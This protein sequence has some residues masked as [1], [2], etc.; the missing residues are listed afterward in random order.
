MATS[1]Q[2]VLLRLKSSFKWC[3]GA[4]NEDLELYKAAWQCLWQSMPHKNWNASTFLLKHFYCNSLILG[5]SHSVGT[6]QHLGVF[7]LPRVCLQSIVQDITECWCLGHNG[8]G[9]VTAITYYYAFHKI[10]WVHSCEHFELANTL[11][12]YMSVIILTPV[13]ISDV[14]LHFNLATCTCPLYDFPLT[15]MNCATGNTSVLHIAFAVLGWGN[16][17][18][19]REAEHCNQVYFSQEYRI[20]LCKSRVDANDLIML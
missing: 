8:R 1:T 13:D 18:G 11:I 10:M 20:S 16:T 12:A 15:C 5:S 6:L 19:D 4:L 9:I 17:Q 7:L 14:L 3:K 2:K